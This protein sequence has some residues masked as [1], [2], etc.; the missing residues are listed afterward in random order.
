M[1]TCLVSWQGT[2]PF[3]FLKEKKKNLQFPS[4][5]TVLHSLSDSAAMSSAEEEEV[6]TGRVRAVA[7]GGACFGQTAHLQ[8]KLRGGTLQA[9]FSDWQEAEQ[10]CVVRYWCSQQR[11][12]G[13]SPKGQ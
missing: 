8:P 11:V 10:H 13:C 6:F 9:G 4:P 7:E 2:P 3:F 1:V 12:S 5:L